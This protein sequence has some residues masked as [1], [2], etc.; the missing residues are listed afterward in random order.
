[1]EKEVFKA[2]SGSLGFAG[3]LMGRGVDEV[4]KAL[5]RP[6]E[7]HQD[8]IPTGLQFR[9]SS[10]N[11]IFKPRLDYLEPQ[12]PSRLN[13][14]MLK[15][16]TMSASEKEFLQGLTAIFHG[17]TE[18]ALARFQDA[19]RRPESKIQLTDAY[20]VL[21]ALQCQLGRPLEA[22]RHLKTALM[23]QQGLGSKVKKWAPSL[24]LILP[25][26]PFSSFTLGPDLLGLT[27]LMAYSQSFTNPQEAVHTLEQLLELMEN[28]P[29][30]LFFINLLRLSQGDFRGVFESLQK[31][32]PD[33][34]L[35]VAC[36]ILLGKACERLGDPLT[37][38]EILR[39]AADHQTLDFTLKLDLRMGIVDTLRAE[40]KHAE[41]ERE[42][43]AV[44]ALDPTHVSWDERVALSPSPVTKPGVAAQLP[45]PDSVDPSGS[46]QPPITPAP[47]EPAPRPLPAEPVTLTDASG[48][49]VK[50]LVCAGRGIEHTLAGRA[51]T[52]GR[53]EGDIVLEGD[54]ASSRTHARITFEEGEYWIEDLGSTN[55]TWVNRHRIRKKVELHRGDV[56]EIGESRFEV[57]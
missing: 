25:L 26:T 27:I 16:L 42:R 43:Q 49:G 44:A 53:E 30:C 1:M 11:D 56:V 23:A 46:A 48:G 9:R 54:N 10:W 28:E 5:H 4:S 35:Q 37:A 7:F 13:V 36:M 29:T 57:R 33:S 19:T 50:A 6:D 3:K 55:G 20:F 17:D 34:N 40:G 22:S 8:P 39:K 45:P 21:G 12:S 18:E 2:L 15:G 14:N 47:P 31:T 41:A 32:L 51:V 52:I 24:T 38:R